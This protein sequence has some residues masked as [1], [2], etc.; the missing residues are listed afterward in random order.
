MSFAS[1]CFSSSRRSMRSTKLFS[2]SPAI[3]PTSGILPPTFHSMGRQ[4]RTEKQ[5]AFRHFIHATADDA[6]LCRAYPPYG[7]TDLIRT[8]MRRA[9]ARQLRHRLLD[10]VREHVLR[11]ALAPEIDLRRHLAVGLDAAQRNRGGFPRALHGIDDGARLVTAMHHAVGA[12]LVI[13]RAVG[14]PIRLFHQLLEAVGVP[15]AEQVARP[16][17]AEIVAARVAPRRAVI[18]L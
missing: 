15:L 6:R 3:P 18:G 4:C 1:A 5:S 11:R 17:P 8:S 7:N 12:F 16:L 10:M 2:R 9:L 14:I 13:A